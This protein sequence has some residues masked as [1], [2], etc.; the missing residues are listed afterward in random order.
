MN[1]MFCTL[2]LV[3]DVL[4]FVLHLLQTLSF[5]DVRLRQ[6]LSGNKFRMSD[7]I[8]FIVIIIIMNTVVKN[9]AKFCKFDEDNNN[10]WKDSDLTMRTIKVFLKVLFS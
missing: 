3:V 5:H 8:N 7:R 4:A 6:S 10:I 9:D 2:Q 1:L